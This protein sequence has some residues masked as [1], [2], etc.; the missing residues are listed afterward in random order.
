MAVVEEANTNT[1][2]KTSVDPTE[3]PDPGLFTRPDAAK[4]ESGDQN[5]GQQRLG[6]A[7]THRKQ[8]S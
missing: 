2:I 5:M 1:P 7:E 6:S 4:W 8:E 3:M